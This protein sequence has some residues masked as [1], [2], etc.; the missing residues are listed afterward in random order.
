MVTGQNTSG[1]EEAVAALLTQR[2]L[3]EAASVRRYRHSTLVRWQKI[4][5]FQ[6]EFANARRAAFGQAMRTLTAR[7]RALRRLRCSRSWS[8]RILRHPR[9]SERPTAF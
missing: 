4:D 1:R 9:E 6:E 3:E 7:I 5:E 2:N 8:I